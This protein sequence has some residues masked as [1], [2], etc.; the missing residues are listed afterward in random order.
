MPTELLLNLSLTCISILITWLAGAFIMFVVLYDEFSLPEFIGFSYIIG[1]GITGAL[2]G[3]SSVM[4][5]RFSPWFVYGFLLASGIPSFILWSHGKRMHLWE[6]ISEAKPL[7]YHEYLLILPVLFIIVGVISGGISGAPNWDGLL[8][9]GFTAKSLFISN[10]INM[11]FFTDVTRYG[12]IHLDYPLLLPLLEYWCYHFIGSDNYQLIQFVSIGYYM[13]LAGIFYGSLKLKT[14][15]SIALF[16]LLIILFNPIV[17]SNSVGGDTDIIVA[18]YLTGI[19]IVYIK[20]L[21]RSSLKMA[22]M[23]GMLTGFLANT[24]NEGFAFFVMFSFLLIFT[25][26]ITRKAWMYYFIP[27]AILGLPWFITK[28]MYGIRSDLFINVFHQIPLMKDRM[29]VI[30]DHYYHFFT[31]TFPPVKGTGFLWLIALIGLIVMLS[32]ESTRSR[33]GTLWLPFVLLFFIYSTVYI[34]TPHTI[35]WQ[36]GYSIL[37]TMT[38]LAPPLLWLST[39]VLWERYKVKKP[40]P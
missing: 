24:K 8:T 1:S 3:I 17:I 15:R 28:L 40:D 16:S 20:L 2:L 7:K 30:L 9:Y 33:Y 25:P 35:Q 34:I 21:T 38:Q 12:H 27:S 29:P 26:G 37:R 4:L 11:G 32:H 22:F 10:K 5:G 14:S 31:G 36:L 13:A 19:L 18:A 6:I 39:V 23:L